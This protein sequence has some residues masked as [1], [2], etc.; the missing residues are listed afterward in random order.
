[1]E[2]QPVASLA[3]GAARRRFFRR[4]NT[5]ETQSVKLTS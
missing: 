4:I 1:M 5:N 2:I 3:T